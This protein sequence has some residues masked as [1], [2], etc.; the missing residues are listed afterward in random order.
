MRSVPTSLALAL[1]WATAAAG[2]PARVDFGTPPAADPATA[3]L[4]VAAGSGEERFAFWTATNRDGELCL[5]SRLGASARP[6]GAYRC[7]RRGLER[8]LLTVEGGGGRGGQIT[9]GVLSGI[10]APDVSRVSVTEGAATQA[11]RDLPLAPLPGFPGW[12]VFT[13]G[14]RDRP[15]D[16]VEAYGSDGIVV[17]DLGLWIHPPRSAVVTGSVTTPAGVVPVIT[18]APPPVNGQPPPATGP[19][20]TDTFARLGVDAGSDRVVTRALALPAL[21][22]VLAYHPAWLEQTT[23]WS[24]CGGRPLGDV[25]SFR[26]R[27]PASFT[28]VLPMIGSANGYAY[29]TATQKIRAAGWSELN[30]SVDTADAAIAGVDSHPYALAAGAGSTVVVQTLAPPR[31]GGGPDDTEPCSHD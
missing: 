21:R 10:A 9:W 16:V 17:R 31:P 15:P 8:P 3:R 30:V 7:L 14:V 4:A 11:K 1:V 27:S 29:T 12:H 22:E 24:T 5:G 20:W 19:A 13:T 26:F 18:V 23:R 6:P 25:V 2:G 28:A